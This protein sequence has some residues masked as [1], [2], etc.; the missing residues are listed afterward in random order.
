MYPVFSDGRPFPSTRS[1]T[2]S[3]VVRVRSPESW[4]TLDNNSYTVEE[5]EALVPLLRRVHPDL[6]KELKFAIWDWM[7]KFEEGA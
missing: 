2:S 1:R 7:T 6:V 5:L 3:S 4:V